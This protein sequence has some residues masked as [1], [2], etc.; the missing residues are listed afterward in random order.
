M[1]SKQ[2]TLAEFGLFTCLTE[3]DSFETKVQAYVTRALISEREYHQE[4]YAGEEEGE[5]DTDSYSSDIESVD[6]FSP[7]EELEFSGTSSPAGSTSLTEEVLQKKLSS[8]PDQ[9]SKR[10]STLGLGNFDLS[11]SDSEQSEST[12]AG[13]ER[14]SKTRRKED[15]LKKYL[16]EAAAFEGTLEETPQ[17]AVCGTSAWDSEDGKSEMEALGLPTAFGTKKWDKSRKS[18]LSEKEIRNKFVSLWE[19][20]GELLVY[21]SFVSI[22]PDY[23]PYYHE[24][25]GCV[26]PLVEVE[27]SC[28]SEESPDGQSTD[29][30]FRTGSGVINTT[31]TDSCDITESI[32]DKTFAQDSSQ[33][34]F[35]KDVQIN[36]DV[37]NSTHTG[38]KVDAEEE[39]AKDLD[40]QND[41][42]AKQ[43]CI[44]PDKD[45]SSSFVVMDKNGLAKHLNNAHSSPDE[46]TYQCSLSPA[47]LKDVSNNCVQSSH[48]Q[49]NTSQ[50][51]SSNQ[52]LCIE[53]VC[54]VSGHEN[55]KSHDIRGS[56]ESPSQLNT[57]DLSESSAGG[58]DHCY[59]YTPNNLSDHFYSAAGGDPSTNLNSN[60]TSGASMAEDYNACSKDEGYYSH[61]ELIAILRGTHEDLQNQIYWHVKEKA[62]DWFRSY[63]DQDF[64]VSTL[65][66]DLVA[67]TQPYLVVQGR[68]YDADVTEE[69]EEEK[70]MYTRGYSYYNE[71]QSEDEDVE[72]KASDNR[73]NISRTLQLLGLVVQKDEEKR[74]KRK[75]KVTHGS[76]VYKRK[77]I[78][79]EAKRL[80]LDFGKSQKLQQEP[81]EKRLQDKPTHIIFDDDD[82][83]VEVENSSADLR[84]SNFDS[85]A[86]SFF[87]E[88][89]NM[90]DEKD[91]GAEDVDDAETELD[92]LT[93]SKGKKKRNK[94][95]KH[96]S[97]GQAVVPEEIA[98]DPVLM[99][100][101]YQRYRLFR[102]F[103]EGIMLDRES[104]FS[105][106][107]EAI[108]AHI[109]ERCRCDT[110]VDAFCGAGG[111]TIQFAFTCNRVIAI[112][113]DEKKLEMAR[114]NAEVYGVADRIEFVLGNYLQLAPTLQ[115]D[116][117]FLSPPWGGPERVTND[118]A[119]FLPRNADSEK[120]TALAG[121]GKQVE[122]EQNFL[123]KKLKTITAYFGDLILGTGQTEHYY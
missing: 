111:N 116:V 69:G 81:L 68:A 3:E 66:N 55:K 47:D 98:K 29:S 63:S 30:Y 19:Q 23:A 118:I 9:L 26:P 49:T 31:A 86:C 100:Y 85:R 12:P 13:K 70:N 7:N 27:I 114:N 58:S 82:N 24:I 95:K 108:A 32:K 28:V 17:E 20:C 105:V 62:S 46:G 102:R 10:L 43:P 53:P 88:A 64:D 37:Y 92:A 60:S 80:H 51:A 73:K 110:I 109:A 14:V 25:A 61:D 90:D 89:Q 71:S 41:S 122:I 91:E 123:N 101:W 42:Q 106:T 94:S 2:Q 103:D 22:Y 77:N 39:V 84:L 104:W 65:E 38:K 78:L 67:I 120:L 112:D 4:F 21:K 72:E 18:K 6:N 59:G 8:D 99:K 93:R 54:T 52:S 107:P 115:A 56:S 11:S 83:P 121:K 5:E 76:V 97:L 119:F 33:E 113:I 36:G 40:S 1:W 16:E 75:R 57:C 87:D 34:M 96:S 44:H 45:T 50:C 35:Q 74:L 117:V 79:K 48:H 15:Y